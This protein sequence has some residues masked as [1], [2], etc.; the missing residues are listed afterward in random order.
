M[1]GPD[2]P[3]EIA[4]LKK[5]LSRA[6]SRVRCLESWLVVGE[7]K[8]Q[9]RMSKLLDEMLDILEAQ[10]GEIMWELMQRGEIAH[11]E[12]PTIFER[13]EELRITKKLLK[14]INNF[15]EGE[16]L[17]TLDHSTI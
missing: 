2:N 17:A 7:A 6:E 13:E 14:I 3:E 5:K 4:A 16:R 9:R 8:I 15:V 11:E 1:S 12:S 10:Y